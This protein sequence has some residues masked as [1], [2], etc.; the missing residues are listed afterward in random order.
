MVGEP[1]EGGAVGRC[2]GVCG[3][4]GAEVGLSFAEHF[5][6]VTVAA[7]A[8]LEEAD[9]ELAVFEAFEVALQ[10]ALHA[11]DLRPRRCELLL[12]GGPLAFGRVGEVGECLFDDVAVAVQLR[13]LGEDGGF[14]PVFGEPVAVA[15]GGAVLVAG[16]AG[17][18][19]VA[20]VASVRRGADVGATAV[21]TTNEPGEEE[22]GRVAASQRCVLAAAAEDLLC[23][24]EGVVVDERCV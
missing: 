8:V 23:L 12:Q 22:V 20:A 11:G 2:V 16:G 17:V 21:V 19:G 9:C 7:D 1:C 10:L 18:V 24:L 5:E 6:A 4:A 15:F 3:E 13:E 14:E